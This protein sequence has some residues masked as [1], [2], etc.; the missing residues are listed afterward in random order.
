MAE[1][2]NLADLQAQ[3]IQQQQEL[4]AYSQSSSLNSAR[5]NMAVDQVKAQATAS[6]NASSAIPSALRGA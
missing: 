2:L 1:P 4:L 5:F 3:Q 6:N